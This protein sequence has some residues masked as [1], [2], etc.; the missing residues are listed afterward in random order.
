MEILKGAKWTHCDRSCLESIATYYSC[1]RGT[2]KIQEIELDGDQY[3]FITYDRL[4]Y[5]YRVGDKI[6][7]CILHPDPM[8]R[9]MSMSP[10]NFILDRD[11]NNMEEIEADMTTCYR[12]GREMKVV[13]DGDSIVFYIQASNLVAKRILSKAGLADELARLTGGS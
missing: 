11:H 6:E 12:D 4:M 2:K 1:L 7:S 10:N 3:I 5:V 13:D 9:A 8:Q